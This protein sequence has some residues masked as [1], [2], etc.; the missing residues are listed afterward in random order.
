MPHGLDHS[1]GCRNDEHPRLLPR[2]AGVK[3]LVRP[4][5]PLKD[6]A[7][8]GCAGLDIRGGL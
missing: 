7:K 8:G 3:E 5:I 4:G 1:H 6:P 2:H